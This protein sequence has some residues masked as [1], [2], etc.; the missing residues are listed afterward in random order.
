MVRTEGRKW[1]EAVGPWLGIGAAPATLTLGAA[2]ASRNDGAVPLLTLL[3]GGLLMAALL[4]GQGMLGLRPPH[5]EGG[6]LTSVAPSYLDHR[7][8]LLLGIVLA[9]AMVGWNGFNVGLG[10]AA[11]AALTGTPGPMGALVLGALVFVA[12]FA[13][14]RLRNR[15]SV[16]TTLC[17][18]A[19]VAF[20]VSRLSPSAS[21]VTLRLAAGPADVAALGGYIAVFA[22]R[23]PDFSHGL[24]RRRDLA[25]CVALLVVP[26][27]CATVAGVGIWLRTGDTDVVAVLARTQSVGNLFVTL[28]V[29][30]PALTTTYSGALA[31]RSVLPRV[32]TPIG[33]VLIAVPGTVLA[34]ARF[35]HYLLP[36][37]AVLAA[38]LPP[39]VIPMA[40]EA[41]RRRR[42][43]PP[44][45]VPL[46][47][48][49]PSGIVA[50]VLGAPMFGLVLAAITTV[51]RH[52]GDIANRIRA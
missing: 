50:V 34:A 29:F 46:W 1:T 44:K 13:T 32:T 7:S 11:L 40:T 16:V 49:I 18:I 33:M 3:A 39:L 10:G 30:T 22:V 24:A 26:A 2:M 37:L 19:L 25:W 5:G 31:L 20:C 12:S 48:W 8:R 52:R 17:A 15:I 42:G 41:W 45:I 28:A 4:A 47:T 36:W 6:T 23:A 21:P 9:L 43:L 27:V 38:L 35:D 51:W 14:P